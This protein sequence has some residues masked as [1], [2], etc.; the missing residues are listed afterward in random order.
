MTIDG[1]R[2]TCSFAKLVNNDGNA[3]LLRLSE[4]TFFVPLSVQAPDE[5]DADGFGVLTQCVSAN[6]QEL[7]ASFDCAVGLYIEVVSNVPP[8]LAFVQGTTP[9]HVILLLTLGGRVMNNDFIP[10]R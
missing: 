3:F 2:L 5:C 7:T 6:L 1:K 9:L 4:R 10:P 8:S